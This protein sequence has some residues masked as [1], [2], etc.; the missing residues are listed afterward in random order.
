M[1][2]NTDLIICL[3]MAPVVAF[4]LLPLALA[5]VGFVLMMVRRALFST[6][7]V[8]TVETTDQLH[9]SFEDTVALP[10][11]ATP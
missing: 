3:W 6:G 5:V 11:G 1:T 8:Y 2:C 7:V 9:D 10:E 4:F